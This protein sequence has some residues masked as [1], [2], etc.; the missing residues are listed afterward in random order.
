MSDSKV[1]I[2]SHRSPHHSGFS[3][4]SRLGQSVGLLNL[5]PEA[6]GIPYRVAKVAAGNLQKKL[7]QYDSLSFQKEISLVREMLKEKGGFAHFLNGERD[8]FLSTYFANKRKWRLSASFHYP[9][10]SLP[11]HLPTYKYVSKLDGLIAVGS[12]QLELLRSFSKNALVRYIPHGVDTNYFK[13]G[14]AEANQF[15]ALFVGVHLRDFD[16]ALRI[17][18][19][20]KKKE[21]RFRLTMVLPKFMK[22]KIKETSAVKAIF[23]ISDDELLLEYQKANCL[24]LP[25]K[26]VTACNSLLEAMACGLP[27]VTSNLPS[28]VTYLQGSDSFLVDHGNTNAWVDA[29]LSVLTD[30][31]QNE[32]MRKKT[33]AIGLTYDWQEVDKL[34]IQF[35]NDLA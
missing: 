24:L 32:N 20:I 12:E 10:S 14:T 26:D 19:E 34:F 29:T 9:S 16:L 1:F 3:G 30:H 6:A 2:I 25:L 22:H 4:Y 23:D 31:R 28:S 21:P 7:P 15:G 33:R 17:A 5:S 35:L 11:K 27:I 8:V 13:P 18:E